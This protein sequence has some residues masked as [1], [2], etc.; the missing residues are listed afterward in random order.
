MDILDSIYQQIENVILS[1]RLKFYFC[2]IYIF[3]S[4]INILI[5]VTTS[6]LPVVKRFYWFLS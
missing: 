1:L 6:M 4:W 5:K 3:V 2:K